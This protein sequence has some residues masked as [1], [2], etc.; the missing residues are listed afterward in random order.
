M[1]ILFLL[2]CSLTS[3]L[4]KNKNIKMNL[5]NVFISLIPFLILSLLIKLFY[6]FLFNKKTEDSP[7]KFIN[8]INFKIFKI[9]QCY[10]HHFL[11][12]C[13]TCIHVENLLGK[14]FLSNLSKIILSL[15]NLYYFVVIVELLFGAKDPDA[16]L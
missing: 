6:N 7:N 3:S 12:L 4:S 9:C 1:Q 10:I 11:C 2:S 14:A 15:R 13:I 16:T 8:L 5:K